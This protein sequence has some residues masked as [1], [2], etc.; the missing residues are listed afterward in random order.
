MTSLAAVALQLAPF[1]TMLSTTF[2]NVLP[3]TVRHPIPT[4]S[5]RTGSAALPLASRLKGKGRAC[6][7]EGVPPDIGSI[8]QP[9]IIMMEVDGEDFMFGGPIETDVSTMCIVGP[10]SQLEHITPFINHAPVTPLSLGTVHVARST[11]LLDHP[12]RIQ[13]GP[14][15][16]RQSSARPRPYSRQGRSCVPCRDN[17]CEMLTECPGHG[18]HSSCSCMSNGKHGD[19]GK[20][21]RKQDNA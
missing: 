21:T 11:P 9:P 1:N 20:P 19:G 17:K 14:I 16:P 6:E 12:G 13:P 8:V 15:R 2:A 5:G 10:S 3:A 7:P 4:P 18:K